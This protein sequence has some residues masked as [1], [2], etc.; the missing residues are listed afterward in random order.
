MSSDLNSGTILTQVNSIL[1]GSKIINIDDMYDSVFVMTACM[2]FTRP[3]THCFIYIL[4][5]KCVCFLVLN[6]I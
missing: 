1:T 6:C 5:E 4:F 2:F 3:A